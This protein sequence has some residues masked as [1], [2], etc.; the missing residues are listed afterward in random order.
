MDFN[1]LPATRFAFGLPQ[2]AQVA[3]LQYAANQACARFWYDKT[4]DTTAMLADEPRHG[5]ANAHQ[6]IADSFPLGWANR[7]GVL[8]ELAIDLGLALADF[9]DQFAVP[10]T[11]IEVLEFIERANPHPTW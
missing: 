1:Q 10:E 5:V 11:V 6:R 2:V 7:F 3:V 8:L 9:V 4:Y